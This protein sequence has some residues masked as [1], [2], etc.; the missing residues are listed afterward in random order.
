[1]STRRIYVIGDVSRDQVSQPFKEYEGRTASENVVELQEFPGNGLPL[2]LNQDGGEAAVRN[3]TFFPAHVPSHWKG[4]AA[5]TAEFIKRFVVANVN[6]ELCKPRHGKPIRSHV[7]LDEFKGVLCGGDVWRVAKFGGYNAPKQLGAPCDTRDCFGEQTASDI[8][9]VDDGGNGFR[10]QEELGKQIAK[11]LN[12]GNTVILK[13]SRPLRTAKYLDETGEHSRRTGQLI[14]LVDMRDLRAEGLNVSRGLSWERTA[15]DF[16][17]N[18]LQDSRF[19]RLMCADFIIARTDLEGA[20]ICDVAKVRNCAGVH[21]DAFTLLYDSDSIEGDLDAK[22]PGQMMGY[23]SVFAAAICGAVYTHLDGTNGQD[24]SGLKKELLEG[25]KTGLASARRLLV[26][27]YGPTAA[28]PRRPNELLPPDWEV[29]PKG[30]LHWRFFSVPVRPPTISHASHRPKVL[31]ENTTSG[32]RILGELESIRISKIAERIVTHGDKPEQFG[33]P[34]ARFGDLAAADRFEAEGYRAIRG[35]MREYL[36]DQKPSAPLC[37]AVF[38]QPGCGKS[39]GVK[40]VAKAVFEEKPNILTFNLSEFTDVSELARAFHLVNDATRESVPLVFFDEFD[41]SLGGQQ[42]AWLKHFLAPM[43]DGEFRDRGDIHPIGKAIF[44]FAGGTRHTFAAFAGPTGKERQDFVAAKGPDFLSRLR[45]YVNVVGPDYRHAFDY[46]AMI[47]RAVLLHGWL[48]KRQEK[49]GVNPSQHLRSSRGG[50]VAIDPF[51]LKALLRIPKFHHGMRSLTAII[52]MSRLSVVHGLEPAALP[53]KAQ[54]DLHVDADMFLA[55]MNVYATLFPE[56]RREAIRIWNTLAR[57]AQWYYAIGQYYDE[58]NANAERGQATQE[59]S[60]QRFCR[61]GAGAGDRS[62]YWDSNVQQ[63]A[64]IPYRMISLGYRIV[65][66]KRF[67]SCGEAVVKGFTAEQIAHLAR[68]EHARWNAEKLNQGWRFA[69][70]RV[71]DARLHPLLVDWTDLDSMEQRKDVDAVAAIPE[72]LD[73]AGFL[74]LELNPFAG[75]QKREDEEPGREKVSSEEGNVGT[76]D[77]KTEQPVTVAVR[78]LIF[79]SNRSNIVMVDAG[80]GISDLPGPDV[81]LPNQRTDLALIGAIRQF[82]EEP[83]LPEHLRFVGSIPQNTGAGDLTLFFEVGRSPVGGTDSLPLGEWSERRQTVS[84]DTRSFLDRW[85][86]AE[87]FCRTECPRRE[88]TE[89]DES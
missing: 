23:A 66:K 82:F 60:L 70:T 77:S 38:G 30:A 72:L 20:L 69:R 74:L 37:V 48:A 81:V 49:L 24:R 73:Q 68:Q 46:G 16:A 64:E 5:L 2:T 88:E 80:D 36:A 85:W 22:I 44:V 18:L 78:A 31:N 28:P 67:P 58:R 63:V 25:C 75:R 8:I 57:G 42:L 7:T 55:L 47:R 17:G 52:D 61:E 40:E 56:D 9:V 83:L 86:A 89:V 10:Y 84:E 4:G 3:Y 76:A 43:Q 50:K 13:L 34:M 54:L 35:L 71:D 33:I 19:D 14:I 59:T 87:E 11:F 53:S 21:K 39:F 15:V 12:M 65:D 27:G 51:V 45:G 1:M 29:P 26:E 79:D 62:R 32:W 41:S 6:V